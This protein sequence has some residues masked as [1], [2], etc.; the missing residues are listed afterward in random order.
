M[1]GSGVNVNCSMEK[2]E[3]SERTFLSYL[4]ETAA[5]KEYVKVHY[6]SE[7]HELLKITG[8]VKS[9]E[10]QEGKP[11]LLLAGGEA[12]PVEKLVRVGSRLAPGHDEDD[13]YSCGC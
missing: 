7:L 13:F 8:V 4:A 6:Y 11:R 5:K 3:T 10:E 9:L 1:Q 12:I 2:T